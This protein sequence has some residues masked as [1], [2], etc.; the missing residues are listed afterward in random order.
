MTFC[1]VSPKIDNATWKDTMKLLGGMQIVS[2]S[3]AIQ[4]G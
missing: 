2:D 1:S 3:D 4:F